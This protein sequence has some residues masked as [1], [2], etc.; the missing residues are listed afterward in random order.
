MVVPP[1]EFRPV[2][3]VPERARRPSV[4]PRRAAANLP[5]HDSRAAAQRSRSR[6]GRRWRPPAADRSRPS[7]PNLAS[8]VISAP[9][10][11]RRT[12]AGSHVGA[13]AGADGGASRDAGAA[14]ARSD[15]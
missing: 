13:H 10:R 12:A 7:N 2:D 4:R 8:T 11:S 6:V 15:R 1:P 5:V 9:C 14:D 3:A